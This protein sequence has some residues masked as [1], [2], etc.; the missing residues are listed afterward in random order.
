MPGEP[1]F[2]GGRK[3]PPVFHP[4]LDAS[5]NNIYIYFF[6]LYVS[7]LF[8]FLISFFLNLPFHVYIVNFVW[9]RN[10][11]CSIHP[12]TSSLKAFVLGH[13]RVL[14]VTL[15]III[16]DASQ[17]LY[18]VLYIYIHIYIC[19]L[20]IIYIYIYINSWMDVYYKQS[21]IC[22]VSR[23]NGI[24]SLTIFCVCMQR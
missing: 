4:R 13:P 21:E 1:K 9:R 23:S 17:F 22:M 8:F 20:Y 3:I 18:N 6:S 11:F 10:L 15:R 5:P 19:I 12:Q 7:F 16:S 14:F 24:I 2:Q